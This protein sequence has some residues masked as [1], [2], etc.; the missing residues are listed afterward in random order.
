MRTDWHVAQVIH[1]IGITGLG[2]GDRVVF[3]IC[4]G[5]V[6][7]LAHGKLTALLS[8]AAAQHSLETQR[9]PDYRAVRAANQ[10]RLSIRW[11]EVREGRKFLNPAGSRWAA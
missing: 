11:D 2:T 5:Q 7:V 9:T 6:Q 8:L 4:D 1:G 3:R 10:V